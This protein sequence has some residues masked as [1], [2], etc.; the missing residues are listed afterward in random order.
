[1]ATNNKRSNIVMESRKRN[2]DIITVTVPKGMKEK[3]KAHAQS[4]GMSM[5]EY[6]ANL[7]TND[8]E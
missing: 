7:I 1:M 3:I 5:N 6:I 2:S 8:M 4:K